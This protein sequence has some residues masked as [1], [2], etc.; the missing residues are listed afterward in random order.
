M[1]LRV[2]CGHSLLFHQSSGPVGPILPCWEG[3]AWR[4]FLTFF[5]PQSPFRDELNTTGFLMKHNISGTK[6]L[7]QLLEAF[8]FQ[9]EP[10]SGPGKR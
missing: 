7:R 1:E 5:M 8:C 6:E 10:H 9:P 3:Q 2:V 4:T